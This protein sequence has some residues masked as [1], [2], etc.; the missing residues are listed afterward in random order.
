M[1]NLLV[2][3]RRESDRQAGSSRRKWAFKACATRQENEVTDLKDM[4]PNANAAELAL[5]ATYGALPQDSRRTRAFE[6][7]AASGLPHRRMEAWKWSDFKAGLPQLDA[8][9]TQAE[10]DPFADFD[11]PV[12]T[13]SGG[14]ITLPEVLPDGVKLH[15]QA[16]PQ[17]FAG[18]EDM[19]LGAL[20]AALAGH[21]G[22]IATLLIE[23]TAAVETPLRLVCASQG[24]ESSFSRVVFVVRPGASLDVYESHLG[25]AGFSGHLVDIGLQDGARFGRTIYQAAGTDQVQ[26]VTGDV[27]LNGGARYVQTMLAFGARVSR[28]ETR[29]THHREGGEAVL[30]AAYLAGPGQHVDVTTHVRHS[31]V[32]CSTRQMTKGAVRDGGKG[33]F[34]GKFHVP[35]TV[36][37][38]TDAAMEHHALLLE[39]GAEVFAK[40][41]LEIYADDVECAHGNT[42]GALDP[43]QLFYMRQRGI[44]DAEA[45]GLL[46]SAFIAE[47]LEQAPPAG[48][49]ALTELAERWLQR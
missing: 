13:I 18:A 7:F 29:L 24:A 19:P 16:D 9:R 28:L 2:R 11:A 32:S 15:E 31:A 34:Q 33:V 37:Q 1:T 5:A 17:A 36:G 40:P 25:G 48:Y 39:N 44:P 14:R 10:Q 12:I 8:P 45:R 46:T 6:A 4:I 49:D 20:T 3:R 47:A 27:H 41:E 38:N 42:C 35:R 26:A 23:V 43:V 21:G 30:N 22:G